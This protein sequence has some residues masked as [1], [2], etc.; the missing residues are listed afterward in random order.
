V[1]Q[2][3]MTHTRLTLSNFASYASVIAAIDFLG[4]AFG[5]V[6]MLMVAPFGQQYLAAVGQGEVLLA[7]FSA[8][9][10]GVIDGYSSR[11]GMCEGRGTTAAEFTPLLAAVILLLAPCEVLALGFIVILKPM[12]FALG[13][14]KSL[15]DPVGAYFAIRMAPLPIALLLGVFARSLRI[16]GLKNF[17]FV[18]V[19]LGVACNIAFNWIFLYVPRFAAALTPERAVALSTV[20]TQAL[21]IVLSGALF[22]VVMYRRRG[23]AVRRP[24]WKA[25]WQYAKDISRAA[26]GIG[27]RHLNDYVGTVLPLLLI[28]T[29]GIS[30]A[31][32]AQV[33]TKIFTIF[34][35]VPQACLAGVFNFY[36]YDIGNRGVASRETILRLLR[37]S[38]VPTGIAALLVVVLDP[39]L[40]RMFSSP[41]LNL[42]LAGVVLFAYMLY[43][44]AY[45][46]EQFFGEC[47]TIHNAG[48]VLFWSST[49]TTYVFTIP[50]A[51]YCVY[52]LH[53]PPL[54]VGSKALST[55]V[56]AAIF[57]LVVHIRL[58]VSKVK[59]VA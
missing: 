53:S 2:P 32:A 20:V 54:A 47:L 37:Y 16:C 9:F 26:P 50:L 40:V 24:D 42:Q 36:S 30:A 7:T 45:F 12:L 14:T 39:Q 17:A 5:T 28:G 44:P 27:V 55:L 21:M 46:L 6:D 15:V 35:R 19:A 1:T 48:G 51:A 18:N 56:L 59:A 58:P 13:Q 23:L 41:G 33:A 57:A 22:V 43:V 25:S 11:L 4:V 29:L 38:A 52:Q 34:C 8:L 3:P 31:A 49:A 10:S